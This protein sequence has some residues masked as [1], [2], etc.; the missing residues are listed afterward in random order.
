[1]SVENVIETGKPTKEAEKKIAQQLK[2]KLKTHFKGYV[3]E[4]GKP[5]LYKIE[6]DPEGMVS[7][8]DQE[9][10]RRGQYP[11]AA[12]RA[13]SC[14]S[15]SCGLHFNSPLGTPHTPHGSMARIYHAATAED[16]G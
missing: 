8:N 2:E 7:H 3:V 15:D 10:V 9:K 5:L 13:V 16:E 4:S 12:H 11:Q 14:A 1:M 6:I